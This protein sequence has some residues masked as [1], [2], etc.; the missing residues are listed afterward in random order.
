MADVKLQKTDQGYYDV[1]F[2]NGQLVTEDS[3][4]TSFIMTI[5]CQQRSEEIDDPVSKG[6]WSGNQLNVDGFEQGSLIWTLEQSNVNEEVANLAENMLENAFQWYID[7]GI[8][9]EINIDV[10]LVDNKKLNATI[11]LLRQDNSSFVR[12]YDL[13]INTLQDAK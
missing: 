9:K 6:G 3:L 2:E 12:N 5:F 13:W 11:E 4:E 1:I 10:K 8:A 7:K